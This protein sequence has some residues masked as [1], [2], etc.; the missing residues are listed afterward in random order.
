MAARDIISE[1]TYDVRGIAYGAS[2]HW[3]AD[4]RVR[5]PRLSVNREDEGAMSDIRTEQVSFT[6][7]GVRCAAELF[8]PSAAD[9]GVRRP[10]VVIAH[11]FS[12]TKDALV[13]TAQFFAS[14]GYVA[15]TF[16]YRCWGES[17]GEPRHQIFPLWE[18]EDYRNAISYLQERREVQGDRIAIWG[19]SYSGGLVI[20]VGA[21]DRRARAV[22]SQVPVVD[23]W[24]WMRALRT[25]EEWE[26]L[27]DRLEADRHRRYAGEPGELVPVNGHGEFCAMP[28][29]SALAAAGRAARG[30]APALH[31]PLESV[32]KVIEFR[33]VS[34]IDKIAPRPLLVIATRGFDTMHPVEQILE[35]F[36]AGLEPK[37]FVGLD[38]DQVGLYSE[39]GLSESLEVAV[40]FLNEHLPIDGTRGGRVRRTGA[41]G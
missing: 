36:D 4:S 6:S 8:L 18:A 2:P 12:G 21:H 38:Y 29:D 1:E 27:R 32:E 23:G 33:P 7:Q 16:D 5:D 41:P 11:G 31:I 10:G 14:A 39:P 13:P 34:V 28:I 20:W 37:R 15:L 35:A 26:E 24:R 19:T 22:I 9:D 30:G 17:D 25:A 3:R 40:S